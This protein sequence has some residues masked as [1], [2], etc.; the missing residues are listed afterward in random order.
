MYCKCCAPC[1]RNMTPISLGPPA[2]YPHGQTPVYLPLSTPAQPV[3]LWKPYPP[4]SPPFDPRYGLVCQT[5]NLP[6]YPDDR[7]DPSSPESSSTITS[8]D[9]QLRVALD[10]AWS[11]GMDSGT[12][13]GV[14]GPPGDLGANLSPGY[15]T[16][17]YPVFPGVQT[18]CVVGGE[19]AT[20]GQGSMVSPFLLPWQDDAKKKPLA[21]KSMY[22]LFRRGP[23][24]LIFLLL[25]D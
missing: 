7:S 8:I 19:R 11:K 13:R 5:E 23:D 1:T 22:F 25:L 4:L 9:C 6:D 24:V 14:A 21:Y 20:S 16:F 10:T 18:E 3:F 2:F 12:L 15:A 17:S